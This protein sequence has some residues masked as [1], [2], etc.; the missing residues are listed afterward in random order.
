VALNSVWNAVQGW[1]D[2]KGDT[3]G[4]AESVRGYTTKTVTIALNGSLSTEVDL[5][6]YAL[7]GLHMP[8]DWTAAVLT[9]Q[10]APISGGTF[11]NVYDD[12]GNEVTVQAA[13]DRAIGVDVAAGALAS[14]RFLKIRSGTAASAVNQ[15][16]ARVITLVLK[17]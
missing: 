5:E 1:L 14:W 6:G 2:Q 10:S 15:A 9:F 11:Y 3:E 7:A 16:A 17:G 13:D 12:Q 8:A 4:H